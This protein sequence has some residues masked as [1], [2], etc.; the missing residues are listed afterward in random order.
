MGCVGDARLVVVVSATGDHAS[1][2]MTHGYVGES[3]D[4][5]IVLRRHHYRLGLPLVI[6]DRHRTLPE[7][8][9]P[10]VLI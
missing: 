6:R 2:D 5:G 8:R 7:E 3:R 10:V 4:V 9:S 1:P